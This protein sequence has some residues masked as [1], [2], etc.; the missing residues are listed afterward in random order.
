MNLMGLHG[1]CMRLPLT[2]LNDKERDELREI[3][4]S[5]KLL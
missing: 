1:G 5:L 2:G 4:R 3:L